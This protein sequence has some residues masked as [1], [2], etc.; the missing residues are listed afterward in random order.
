MKNILAIAFLLF[1]SGSFAQFKTDKIA[2]SEQKQ[3][4]QNHKKKHPGSINNSN[5]IY[6]RLEV[7]VNPAIYFIAGN[8]TTHFIPSGPIQFIE[9]DLSD[10]MTVDSIIFHN[11]AISFTHSAD[12]IHI[13]FPSQLPADDEDS[14]KVYYHGLPFWNSGFGSFVQNVHGLD[15]TPVIWTLSEPYGAKDWWPCKQDLTDKIDSLDV[16]ITTPK[17]Y[18]A[19]SNGLLVKETT[20]DS[21]KTYYWKH[22]YP[23]AAYLVCLAVSNY[24]VFYNY[25]P[26]GADTLPVMNFVYP[27]DSATLR[28]HSVDVISTM[29]LYDTLFGLYPFDKEKYGMVEFGWDGGMEHQTMTF[30]RNFDFELI[31]HELAHHWFGDKVTC[32][33]WHDIWL[34]EGFATYLSV[35]CYEHIAPIWYM[36]AKMEHMYG[37]TNNPNGSVWCDDTTSVDRIFDSDMSYSK[38]AMVL[39]MLRW[40][41]GDSLFFAGL[42]NYLTDVNNAYAFAA[43]PDLQ[44]HLETTSGMD[45]SQFFNT[46]VYGK[47]FPSY[48]ID[49]AQNFSNHVDLVINQTQ[50][51]P[52][53]PFFS[54][55]LPLK[56]KNALHDTIVVFNHTFSG[57][58]F[59]VDL[60][61]AADSLIFDPDL[62]IISA[63]D[64]ITNDYIPSNIIAGRSDYNFSLRLSPNPVARLLR[65]Q[66]QAAVEKSAEIKIVNS[67]GQF[68]QKYQQQLLPGVNSFQVNVAG[69]AS[70][71][72]H[73]SIQAG[74]NTIKSTFVVLSDK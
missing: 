6:Q 71:A 64:T 1:S 42:R 15:N 51:D 21:S 47:G 14:V 49:W 32:A 59:S 45:L 66:V 60:P 48:Q 62:W 25:V 46:W 39:H 41:L 4:T 40:K 58:T 70:G 36:P 67:L 65:I 72:Y 26:F 2:A 38:G 13:V 3:L 34:N 18:R 53:V 61:F 7:Q 22:R 73:V 43:T 9:F 20:I 30:V 56:F 74:G 29:Q 63:Y 68:V 16:I 23:I 31:A 10:S 17:I 33:S 12:V 19:A 35:L 44:A 27:E 54:M 55:P 69:W 11:T 5:I 28:D 37:A 57:Q 8:V 24:D 52:S 50:S